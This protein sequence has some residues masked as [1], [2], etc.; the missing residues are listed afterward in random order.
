MRRRSGCADCGTLGKPSARTCWR[1]KDEGTGAGEDDEDCGTILVVEEDDRQGAERAVCPA[2]LW[3]LRDIPA[4]TLCAPSP[5]PVSFPFY[6]HFL[7][8]FIFSRHVSRIDVSVVHVYL[9]IYL[10]LDCFFLDAVGNY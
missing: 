8:G 4:R 3:P 2:S 6:F 1:E 10:L 7:F 5:E 9:V